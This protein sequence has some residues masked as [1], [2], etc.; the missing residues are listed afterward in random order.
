MTVRRIATRDDGAAAVEFALILPVLV[1]LVLGLIEFSLLFNAQISVTNA[2][3][4]G[5]RVMAIQDDPALARAAAIVAAP[6]LSPALVAG[7]ITVTPASCIAGTSATVQ[8]RYPAALVTGFFGV[9]LPL[10]GKG[11]MLCGG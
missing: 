10:E 2:A 6:S 7:N 1:L 4:E 3:R 5:A 11:V 8:I 9:T